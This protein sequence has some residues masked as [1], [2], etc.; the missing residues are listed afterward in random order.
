MPFEIS[1]I[2]SFLIT[3]IS[4]VVIVLGLFRIP[5]YKKQILVVILVNC[6]THPVALYFIHIKNYNLMLVELCV[7]L[8]EGFLYWYI[9]NM[10]TKKSFQI[11][12]FAN[13]GSFIIGMV[14]WHF[15]LLNQ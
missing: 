2:Y 5:N 1:A 9:L 4:E 7:F 15:I 11:S 6:I 10:S 14:I 8:I 3:V 12:F 13:M